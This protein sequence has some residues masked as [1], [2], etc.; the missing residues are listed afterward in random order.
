MLDSSHF[1][2]PE[3]WR[4]RAEESRVLA[5]MMNDEK[6]K[7]IMLGIA[8]DYEKLATRAAKRSADANACGG[9]NFETGGVT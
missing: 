3:H 5:E 6:A 8:E 1:N 9:W 7:K 2:D 4:R